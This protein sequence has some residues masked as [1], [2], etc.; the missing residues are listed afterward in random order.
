M[1][2][3]KKTLLL[4]L[5]AIPTAALCLSWW[6]KCAF[7]RVTLF[8]MLLHMHESPSVLTVSQI[9][10][11]LL[12]GLLFV[13][14]M[15]AFGWGLWSWSR[16]RFFPRS[17]G[18][19]LA[20]GI[21]VVVIYSVIVYGRLD[22][23]WNI[24]AEL[25]C[26]RETSTFLSDH[27]RLVGEAEVRFP[28][29]KKN[30]VILQVESAEEA[31]TG[32]D[33][34]GGWLPNL[35]A[36]RQENLSFAGQRQVLCTE[37]TIMAQTAMLFGL[38]LAPWDSDFSLLNGQRSLLLAPSIFRVL[39]QGGYEAAYVA[40]GAMLFCS[41]DRMFT[42]TP[43]VKITSKDDFVAQHGKS[44]VKSKYGVADEFVLSKCREEIERLAKTGKPFVFMGVTVDTH[45]EGAEYLSPDAIRFSGDKVEDC[46]RNCDLRIADLVRWI[47]AQPYAKD[48]VIV[49]LGD[50]LRHIGTRGIPWP[51]G[52]AVFNL[53][54]RPD[55]CAE[56]IAREFATFDWAPT[57]IELTGCEL[58]DG[59]MGLGTSLLHAGAKTL[60]EE[61]GQT[62]LETEMR[63]PCRAYRDFM[64]CG[65][66][67]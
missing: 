10:Y 3:I 33:G 49:V 34:C 46:W 44:V 27:C 23:K 35:A 47:R 58:R 29:Q 45:G 48:T 66:R 8:L 50:H 36:L 52:G 53:I 54:V 62:V 25:K 60:L 43:E 14:L 55:G 26:R 31:L 6:I 42:A 11:L 32:P 59:K 41:T 17:R 63:K 7:G 9:G 64:Y 37:C 15:G 19:S 20:L 21:G 22:R 28:E 38:L 24:S 13:V 16:W 57:L 67:R 61:V 40:G 65:R 18:L 1:N 30:L 56:R 2:I 5:L 51:R 39:I 4:V 12:F